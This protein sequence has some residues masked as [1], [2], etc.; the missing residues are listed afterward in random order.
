MGGGAGPE[1]ERSCLGMRDPYEILGVDRKSSATDIKSAYRRLAKKLHPDA[2]KNDPKA[3]WHAAI[4]WRA[5][6][7]PGRRIGC[8]APPAAPARAVG[9]SKA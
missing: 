9:K 4:S 6:S 3:A 1:N 8:K 7:T 2:N 5:T